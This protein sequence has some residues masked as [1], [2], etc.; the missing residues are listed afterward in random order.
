LFTRNLTAATIVAI[1]ADRAE[2]AVGVLY[3][4]LKNP[5]ITLRLAPLCD[6][7][8]AIS[9]KSL[10]DT[11][12]A[13]EILVRSGN[14][15]LV[16]APVVDGK[17]EMQLPLGEYSMVIIN[18]NANPETL[19][20]SVGPNRKRL[21]LGLT[22]LIPTRLAALIG[23]EAPELRGIAA[24]RNGSPVTLADLR[25]KVVILDFWGYWRGP[26]LASM[27][28]LMKVNDAF[29]GQNVALIAVHDGSLTS[30][31]QLREKTETAKKEIW[32]GRELPFLI[33]LAG[34]APT[35]IDGTPFTANC[36]A[37]ADYGVTSFPTT[38]LINQQGRVVTQLNAHDVESMKKRIAELLHK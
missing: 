38:L 28:S 14:V 29:A 17:V 3:A 24:W 36:Q 30:L 7:T 22:T 15:N 13:S 10:P 16:R 19:N 2:G 11:R 27:P 12:S 4:D 26:C 1:N 8:A 35:K 34:N 18:P 6:V 23:H 20:F 25:G 32:H 31:D 21:S 33:A 9:N 37:T 5:E